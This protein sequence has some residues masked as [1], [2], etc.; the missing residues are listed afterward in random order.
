GSIYKD[1]FEEY[2]TSNEKFS[3]LLENN[4][5]KTLIPPT[6]YFIYKNLLSLEMLDKAEDYKQDIILNHQ[7]SKYAEILL[8]PKSAQ[9]QKENSD[10]IYHNHLVKDFINI[11]K[12]V[13]K[14]L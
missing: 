12:I 11:E 14:Y 13:S 3:E 10:E 6:K 7:K 9:K 5:E 4:P 1:Q 8:D 2:K